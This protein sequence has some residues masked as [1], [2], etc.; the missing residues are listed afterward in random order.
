MIGGGDFCWELLSWASSDLNKK[1]KFKGFLDDN[2]KFIDNPHY[3]GVIK[4]YKIQSEDCFVCAIGNPKPKLKVCLDIENRGGKFINLIHSSAVV[5]DQAK[6]GY[7]CI[8]APHTFIS[9]DTK[10]GNHVL[11]NVSA[12]AGH[13]AI[14]ADGCTLSGHADIT[15]HVELEKG[16]FLGS[17]ASIIPG[18]KI[19]AFSKIGAGSVVIKT[20]KESGTY[21]G[22]P[23]KRISG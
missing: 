18:R 7:G 10:I 4:D 19:A 21:F 16:V 3:L 5:S 8:F 15:G 2:V 9:C 1:W 20:I 6:F 13:N 17:H 22:V 11:I 14:I 12:T 23:A